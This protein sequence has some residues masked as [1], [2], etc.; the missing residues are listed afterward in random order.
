MKKDISDNN[1]R[2]HLRIDGKPVLIRVPDFYKESP[3]KCITRGEVTSALIPLDECTKLTLSTIETFVK[4]NVQSPKYKPLWL[5]DAM[6]VNISKW[7]LFDRINCDGSRTPSYDYL[8][9][10]GTYSVTLQVSHVYVGP[11]KGGET[12]SL[13]LHIKHIAYKSDEDIM[14]IIQSLDCN[15]SGPQ[16]P[17]PSTSQQNVLQSTQQTPKKK[18]RK[19]RRA[20]DE[21]QQQ[22][23]QQNQQLPCLFDGETRW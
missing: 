19:N 5:K 16:P 15:P 8:L 9:G 13:S 14:D 12:F 23:Q 18:G 4:A 6:Y 10:K 11:H 21:N 17:P 20:K 7:C 22:R 2:Q 3:L 1:Y